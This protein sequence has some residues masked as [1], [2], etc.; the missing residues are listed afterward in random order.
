MNAISCLAWVK[1]GIARSNPEK[2]TLDEAKLKQFVSHHGH[3][4]EDESDSASSN[5]S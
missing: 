5:E 3:G 2:V 4:S 1:R